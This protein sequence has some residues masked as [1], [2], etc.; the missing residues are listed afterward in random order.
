MIIRFI[1]LLFIL[2]VGQ[3]PEHGV[4][5]SGTYTI[6]LPVIMRQMPSPSEIEPNDSRALAY[7]PIQLG[8]TLYGMQNDDN[9]HYDIFSFQGAGG[10][11]IRISLTNPP[12]D[13]MQ[14]MLHTP[15]SVLPLVY[16]YQPPYEINYMLPTN[17]TYLIVIFF[18]LGQATNEIYELNVYVP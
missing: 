14:L 7:G 11:A 15:T 13:D 2:L 3:V 17:G 4:Q 18:P 6:A 1:S 16:D 5:G 12:R 9:D 8:V 10:Q